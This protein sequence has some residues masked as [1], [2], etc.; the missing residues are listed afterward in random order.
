MNAVRKQLGFCPQFD[1]LFPN[2]TVQE[3][4]E[5]YGALKGA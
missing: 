4:L 5:F 3:H 1:I 2:L